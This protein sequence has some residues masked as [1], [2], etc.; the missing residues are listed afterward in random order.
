M[1]YILCNFNQIFSNFLSLIAYNR[2]RASIFV[3]KLFLIHNKM[4]S[5]VFLYFSLIRDMSL[6]Y[7]FIHAVITNYSQLNTKNC[8]FSQ[9]SPK[10]DIS[11]FE[12]HPYL[13]ADLKGGQFVYQSEV[14]WMTMLKTPKT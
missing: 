12:W 2:N 6:V 7:G 5:I 3:I 1:A 9:L 4:F 13:T 8:G 11:C 14:P 10:D